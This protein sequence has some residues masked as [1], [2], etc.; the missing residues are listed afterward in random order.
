M[1][2]KLVL[3]IL[4]FS[5]GYITFAQ[6]DAMFSH[7]MFNTQ[8][9]NPGYVGSRQVLSILSVH[10]SQWL[11]FDGA[12]TTQT[13]SINTPLFNDQLGFGFSVLN[14]KIGPINSTSFSIDMA[15]HLQ[16]TQSGHK[17]SFGL[18]G[19]GNRFKSDFSILSLDEPIDPAFETDIRK[20]F[21]PNVGFGLYYNTPKYY[22]GASVPNILSH[23]FDQS[24][25]HLF[26]IGG[27]IL[28][29]SRD[30]K[31]RPSVFIKST[32]SA[33]VN[34]DISAYAVFKDLFWVGGMF[35]TAMGRIIP[36]A[37]VGGGMGI[38]AGLNINDNIAIGYSFDYS[39]GNT[40]F[41]YNGGSHEIMLRYDFIFKKKDI[42][43]S[44]RYF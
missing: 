2:K 29:I 4:F 18:K 40:T 27:A 15:Y 16:V 44:P 12:P 28:E 31:L 30:I 17:L 20:K 23:E 24:Q 19:G 26:L 10:R 11:N 25:T 14:D 42:I 43:K 9:I 34:M 13:L 1:I 41:K 3:F 5:S 21:L 36:S 22:I 8:S 38:M 33:P 7:Y 35:R 39:L 32:K 6:Q 37:K